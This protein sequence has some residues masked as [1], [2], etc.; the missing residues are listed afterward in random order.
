[1]SS[2]E[3]DAECEGRGEESMEDSEDSSVQQQSKRHSA[4]T[5]NIE[6]THTYRRP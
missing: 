4:T 6:S 1:M 2:G 5:N 3:G